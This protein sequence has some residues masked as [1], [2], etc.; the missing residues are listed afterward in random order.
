MIA[1]T[2]ELI[3]G[4]AVGAGSVVLL[5]GAG[6]LLLR[7]RRPARIESPEDAATAVETVLPG[8]RVSGAV[9]GAD[10]I[11]A[12]A[13]TEDGRVAAVKRLGRQLVACEVAWRAVRST[14]RGILVETGDRRLGEVALAGVDA[15]DIRRL[16]PKSF[17]A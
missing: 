6:W 4:T 12:L 16:A 3:A 17:R 14:E 1:I 15:L 7:R 5:G 13:V 10:G 9:V 2:P 11:G 8:T